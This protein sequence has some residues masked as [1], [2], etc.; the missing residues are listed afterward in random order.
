MPSIRSQ[1]KHKQTVAIFGT[2]D[3]DQAYVE[4]TLLKVHGELMLCVQVAFRSPLLNE[5][6]S[7]VVRK[8]NGQIAHVLIV[9]GRL[10]ARGAGGRAS[11]QADRRKKRL[12]HAEGFSYSAPLHLNQ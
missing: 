6:A 5:W 10:A 3:T 9:P 11:H 4:P 12:S 2:Y 8:S 1:L 7:R